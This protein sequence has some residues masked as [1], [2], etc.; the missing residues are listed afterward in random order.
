MVG[1]MIPHARVSCMAQQLCWPR[2]AVSWPLLTAWAH[3]K[4]QLQVGMSCRS[5]C[6]MHCMLHTSVRHAQRSVAG[7]PSRAKP[8]STGSCCCGLMQLV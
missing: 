5:G 3:G 7:T 1:R 6:S 8:R 4:G 2:S